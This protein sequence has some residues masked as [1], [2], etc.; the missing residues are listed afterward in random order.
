[1][2]KLEKTA[3]VQFAFFMG[4]VGIL[5]PP[6]GDLYKYYRDYTLYQGLDFDVFLLYALIE[7]DY[8]LSFLLFGLSTVEL[9]CD[10]SRFIFNFI[11]FYLLGKL[12]FQIV[13][14]NS[15][16]QNKRYRLQSFVIFFVFA[17]A[18]FLYRFSFACI[19]FTYGAYFIIYKDKKKYWLIIALSVLTHF[20]FLLFAVLLFCSKR[21]TMRFKRAFPYYLI[22][23]VF[24]FGIFNV[25]VLFNVDDFAGAVF[26]RYKGYMDTEDAGQYAEGFSTRYLIWKRY[27]YFITLFLIVPFVKYRRLSI[28]YEWSFID[29]LLL[30]CIATSPFSVVFS[31][32]IT[33]LTMMLKIYLLKHF[34]KENK[35]KKYLFVIFSLVIL[36]DFM[37]IWA[38]RHEISV[39]DMSV[40]ATSTSITILQHSYSDNWVDKNITS[41]GD[42]V[43]YAKE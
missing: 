12:Y 1:M 34:Q 9:P 32:F 39:S 29:Y 19:L 16:L 3:F 11:G 43:K 6:S 24:L 17:F 33:P 41:R 31:R 35:M 28:K 5:Y 10:L 15:M 40:L 4:L 36:L 37:N 23:I 30:A 42:L 13:L 14:D 8:L 22:F 20:S 26:E 38:K 7:F 18:A 27:E 21:I 2:Y 25:G